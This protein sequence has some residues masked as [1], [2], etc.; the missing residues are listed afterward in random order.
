MPNNTQVETVVRDLNLSLNTLIVKQLDHQVYGVFLVGGTTLLALWEY[1]PED[2]GYILG[3]ESALLTNTQ[4]AMRL[5]KILEPYEND[6][7][8]WFKVSLHTIDKILQ[9]IEFV[10]QEKSPI[11]PQIINQ[12]SHL[13][14][15]Q[16]QVIAHEDGPLLVLG[17]AGCGKTYTMSLKLLNILQQK[18]CNSY[19][20]AICSTQFNQDIKRHFKGQLAELSEQLNCQNLLNQIPIFS[21]EDLCFNLLNQWKHPI[22]KSRQFKRLD[23]LTQLLFMHENFEELD[24]PFSEGK[25]F[26][27]WSNRWVTIQYLV[28]FFN[29]ITSELV[30]PNQ[31]KKSINKFHKDLAKSYLKYQELLLRFNYLDQGHLQR[32]VLEILTDEEFNV[33]ANT[34]LQYLFLENY[35]DTSFLQEQILIHF[36]KRGIYLSLFAD[37]LQSSY[38]HKGQLLSNVHTFHE[39]YEDYKI[40]QLNINFSAHPDITETIEHWINTANWQGGK[41]NYSFRY[42]TP[43]Q[44][45]Q[46]VDDYNYPSVFCVK[47]GNLQQEI[48]KLVDFITYLKQ[49]RV[50]EDLNQIAF[51]LNRTDKTIVMPYIQA[52]SQKGIQAFC[53]EL[54]SFFEQEEIRLLL[55]IYAYLLG[56]NS[57][58]IQEATPGFKSYLEQVIQLFIQIQ[59]KFPMLSKNINQLKLNINQLQRDNVLDWSLLRYF[60]VFMSC[61]PFHS[62]LK[63]ESSARYLAIFSHLIAV[64]QNYFNFSNISKSNL[65]NLRNTLFG[66]FF[67]LIYEMNL[68]S[69]LYEMDTFPR[70]NTLQ[71][72]SIE[73]SKN[74]HFPVVITGS[75]HEEIF[76]VSEIDNELNPY[77]YRAMEP[78]SQTLLFAR[79]RQHYLAFSRAS[80]LLVLSSSAWPKVHFWPLWKSLTEWPLEQ[81]HFLG[82]QQF[83]SIKQPFIK[84]SFSMADDLDLFERCPRQYLYFKKY[85]F[86]PHKTQ[87]FSQLVHRALLNIHQNILLG[88]LDSMSELRVRE[89]LD[90]T[91]FYLAFKEKYYI[92]HKTQNEAFQ[93]LMN[94]VYQNLSDLHQ[95]NDVNKAVTLEREYYYLTAQI[96]LMK[97]QAEQLDLMLIKTLENRPTDSAVLKNIYRKVCAYAYMWSQQYDIL[98]DRLVMYWTSEEKKED[99]L[100]IF[101]YRPLFVEEANQYFDKIV[102]KIIHH[103]FDV[104]KIPESE[105]CETCDFKKFC[106]T[107][108][109]IKNPN[110]KILKMKDEGL[111]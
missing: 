34:S 12:F 110:Q 18:K 71:I 68:V 61:E 94:Y 90:Q 60:Y 6:L 106:I 55:S 87:I 100:T 72:M 67:Q 57:D 97:T 9:L 43:I 21:F 10:Y 59:R 33:E 50:I 64:F 98:P 85:R 1:L 99:A 63:H 24:I 45:K 86:S 29:K 65:E 80:N 8:W 81:V 26:D 101:P 3:V 4:L 78:K 22:L 107:D 79:M 51:L 25:Y 111:S 69:K 36:N 14:E 92:D 82:R 35:Q 17:G 47:A 95:V 58:N 108:G 19:Q 48:N 56:L 41:T 46:G 11:S 83:P 37:D 32:T 73:R 70:A 38:R 5:S 31:M 2:E 77:Y 104:E 30:N 91:S 88:K 109:L 74:Y 105:V 42:P 52:F 103:Q 96:D 89:I 20:V 7:N 93:I 40:I 28:E 44:A 75:L 13:T 102:E 66:H 39:R 16:K 76:E 23:H 53:K 62:Y 84:P 15:S 54:H 49:H 27:R